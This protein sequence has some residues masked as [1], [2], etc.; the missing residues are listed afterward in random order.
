[1]PDKQGSWPGLVY[2]RPH[3][4]ICI[5][6]D[7]ASPLFCSTSHVLVVTTKS[8]LM[9]VQSHPI[10]SCNTFTETNWKKYI[11]NSFC[12]RWDY[13]SHSDASCHSPNVGKLI[14]TVQNIT[15]EMIESLLGWREI[16]CKFFSMILA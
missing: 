14:V 12:I 11:H 9:Y 3:C 15:L 8:L 1:M 2:V 13:I 16:S 10:E 7:Q 5:H 6:L 4:T